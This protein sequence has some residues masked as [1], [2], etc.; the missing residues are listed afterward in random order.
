MKRRVLAAVGA[1]GALLCATVALAVGGGS[2]DPLVSKSYVDGTY[3]AQ[4]VEQA[5]AAVAKRHDA[6]YADAEA[7]LKD[8]QEG[9]LAQLGGG[10]SGG[11]YQAAFSDIRVKE[12]DTIQVTAG[13]GFLLLAGSGDLSCAG[14]KTIDLSNGWEKGSG[15]LTQGRRYLVMEDTVATITVTSPTAVL[16]LE[17]WHTLT[18]SGRTDYNALA[19]ALRALHR[20]VLEPKRVFITTG[21]GSY[22]EVEL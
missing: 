13:S 7:G 3:T 22:R 11:S 21:D 14:K 16:S 19:D 4:M 15:A 17:G 5:E 2:E 1:T 9:Y 8:K 12:G 10:T 6:L 18:E 20:A